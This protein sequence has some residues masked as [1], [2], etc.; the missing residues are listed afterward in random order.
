M[1]DSTNSSGGYNT[2][3]ISRLVEEI[4]YAFILSQ[5]FRHKMCST[6]GRFDRRLHGRFV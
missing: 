6:H 1:L 4:I 2:E 5:E 3:N